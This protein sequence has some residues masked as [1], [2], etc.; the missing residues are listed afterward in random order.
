[1]ASLLVI[2]NIIRYNTDMRYFGIFLDWN[3]SHKINRLPYISSAKMGVF[4]ITRELHSGSA[5]MVSHVQV[6]HGKGRRTF[7]RGERKSGGLCKQRG[8]GF[9][10]AESLQ[11]R[12]VF[13]LPTGLC[14]GHRGW[15]LP[16]LVSWG[17][18][19]FFFFFLTKSKEPLN[20]NNN[21]VYYTA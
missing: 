13:L 4:G 21:I 16:F 9:S 10:L 5:S 3:G 15:A 12:T 2:E 14:Y 7:Y 19:L 1:M 18:C 11:E 20:R 17:F 6:P 8:S